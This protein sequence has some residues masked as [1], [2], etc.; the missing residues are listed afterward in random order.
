VFCSETDHLG[1]FALLSLLP[2]HATSAMKSP[3]VS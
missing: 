2:D 3:R 1:S